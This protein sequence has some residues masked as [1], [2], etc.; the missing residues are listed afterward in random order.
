MNLGDFLNPVSESP[1]CENLFESNIS[2]YFLHYA[3]KK[4]PLLDGI[5]RAFWKLT[6]LGPR[7]GVIS[8][9]SRDHPVREIS[10]K[11]IIIGTV[12]SSTK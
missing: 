4:L 3:A 8:R 5:M 2:V 9:P 1:C 11:A 10:L 12:I 7:E 6:G